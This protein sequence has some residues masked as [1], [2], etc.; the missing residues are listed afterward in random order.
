MNSFTDS[1]WR[2]E[3]QKRKSQK[4]PVHLLHK[5]QSWG[6]C[7]RQKLLP[8]RGFPLYMPLE[9]RDL[10]LP[11]KPHF[12]L[13]QITISPQFFFSHLKKKKWT[14]SC[15]HQAFCIGLETENGGFRVVVVVIHQ[16]AVNQHFWSHVLLVPSAPAH[17][18]LKTQSEAFE[19]QEYS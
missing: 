11:Q 18:K 12:P 15:T 8:S 2:E 13:H 16:G 10:T 19:C 7:L 6:E 1:V 14:K 5:G 4:N 3:V 17:L 9:P